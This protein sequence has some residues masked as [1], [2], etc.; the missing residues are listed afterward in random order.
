[1]NA[2][3]RC[4][5][6]NACVVLLLSV[7]SYVWTQSASADCTPLNGW[8]NKVF[9][10]TIPAIV[11]PRDAPIGTTLFSQTV[12]FPFG[13]YIFTNCPSGLHEMYARFRNGW[14]PDSSGVAPTNLPGIG[15]KITDY[16]NSQ[17]ATYYRAASSST[18]SKTYSS[19]SEQSLF[20]WIDDG[21]SIQLVK[22]GPTSTGSLSTGTVAGLSLKNLYW[23]TAIQIVNGGSFSTSGCTINTKSLTVPLGSVKRSE[24]SGVGSTTKTS[25]FNISVDCSESTNVTMTLNATADSSSAPGVIAIDPSAG[26]TTASGVGIQLLR[27][28]NS[29]VIGSPFYIGRASVAGGNRIEMGARYYQ[30][31]STITAGQANATATFTLTYN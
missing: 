23:M 18:A 5:S 17:A 3:N 22:T 13:Q 6:S 25:I 2:M 10:I 19:T 14:V 9:N 7:I 4:F 1:M 16:P 28:N 11:I 31:K 12:S 30:T 20:V 15:I 29:V 8:Q 27:N 26:S 21:F 24:F